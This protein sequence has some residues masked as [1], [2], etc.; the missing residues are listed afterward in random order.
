MRT[1][2]LLTRV[3]GCLACLYAGIV[4]V[5]LSAQAPQTD[6]PASAPTVALSAGVADGLSGYRFEHGGRA[7]AD[8][9]TLADGSMLLG[10]AMEWADQVLIFGVDGTPEAIDATNVERIEYRRLARHRAKPDR[11]DLTV[12]F[13][14][15]LPR[16]QSLH[17]KVIQEDG[18]SRLATDPGK[19]ASAPRPGATVTFRVNV[20]NAGWRASADTTCRILIDGNEI[21]SA[22]LG[23]LEP[24]ATTTIDA[25]WAWQEGA[26]VIRVELAAS[27]AAPEINRWNNT[28]EDSLRAQAVAVVVARSVLER[29]RNSPNAVDSFCVEDWVQYQL[30]C[31]NALFARSVYPTTPAGVTERVRCDRIVVVD[32]PEDA[33]QREQS[34]AGLRQGGK[35]DGLAEYAAIMIFDRAPSDDSLNYAA[36]KVDWER[37]K[38]VCLQLGLVDLMKLDTRPDQCLATD[39]NG[40]YVNR[41]HLYPWPR[42]L[43]H[44]PGGFRLTEIESAYLNRVVGRPRGLQGEYLYALPSKIRVVV[45]ANNGRPLEAVTIDAY[46]LHGEGEY[47]GMIA[48]VGARDPLYSA[49]TDALGSL[50]LL[51]QETPE[52][53]T[54][55]GY[56]LRANPFGRIASD[57]S[58][59]LLLLKLA[60]GTGPEEF[61]FVRV[62]D[63]ALAA[64]QGS[65]DE[66]VIDIRTRFAAHETPEA[67]ASTAILM[68]PRDPPRTPATAVW[69]MG[70][71]RP[72]RQ[73]DEFRVFRRTSLGG[74][75]IA[76]W[77]LVAVKRR[78]D[79]TSWLRYDGAYWQPLAGTR[80]GYSADTFFAVS[81]VDREGRESA[82]ASPGFLA[83]Q[84]DALKLAIHRD[85]AIITLTGDGPTQLLWWDGQ[86]GTQPYGVR[87]LRFPGYRPA[88]AGIAINADGRV[89]IT[90][91]VNHVL[92]FYDDAG[93]LTELIPPREA[94]PGFASD[95]P[96]E[97]YAPWDVAVD[98]SGRIYVADFANDRV[99]ILDG[100]GRFTGL[101]DESAG[102]RG[103]H[104]VAVSNKHLCVTDRDGSRCRVY[105]ISGD[106]PVFVREIPRLFD[107]DRALVGR[108]GRV[109]LTGRLAPKH[110]IGVLVFNPDGDG[111]RFDRVEAESKI[112]MGKV[113]S[114]RG[115]YFF[116]NALGDDYGYFVNSFPFDV[117]RVRLD[118]TPP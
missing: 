110:D 56:S 40:R 13:I 9:V 96:G 85:H 70:S 27:D 31:L 54:P 29:F 3:A 72:S 115:M 7:F 20:L 12:A 14:E 106:S 11:P 117:R 64:L 111:A 35:A 86:V 60:H 33:A 107:A 105:D 98:E 67:Q 100:S 73:V 92:A 21:K 51:D 118:Y 104:A 109:Y 81:T 10:K 94:W 62:V 45:R 90:D 95:E 19:V 49:P 39:R 52:Y 99:Q 59:G 6:A 1:N 75:D 47:A 77:Q 79:P 57:G 16:D 25:T 53:T 108:E 101:V 44:T 78:E 37:L 84:K 66:M 32:D 34:E 30:R 76:P 41:Q 58:N 71:M 87:N 65:R 69:Y 82:L 48:G 18:V 91:P 17:G 26:K 15:R 102:F 63:C 116:I 93:E 68:D 80:A 4:A 112:D 83:C 28:F 2:R 114:P 22:R 97:F 8:L 38:N 36:L 55:N 103:P 50:T 46:Q 74:E 5:R 61:H 89:V 88:F 43:M 23:P 24:G 113:Y 42:T